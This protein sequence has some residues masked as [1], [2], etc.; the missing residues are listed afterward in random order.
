MINPTARDLARRPPTEPLQRRGSLKPLK[1]VSL[2]QAHP[3]VNILLIGPYGAGKTILAGSAAAD[4]RIKR[5]LYM[6]FDDGTMSLQPV[7]P[8]QISLEHAE[9]IRVKPIKNFMVDL[10]ETTRYLEE[11]A[12][13]GFLEDDEFPK[14]DCIILDSLDESQKL[15]MEGIRREDNDAARETARKMGKNPDEIFPGRADWSDYGVNSTVLKSCIRRIKA[16][17]CHLIVTCKDQDKDDETTHTRQLLLPRSLAFD[18][19]GLFD[20]V[21]WIAQ[22]TR[23]NREEKKRE[24][25]HVLHCKTE[26]GGARIAKDRSRRLPAEI[27]WPTMTKIFDYLHIATNTEATEEETHANTHP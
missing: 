19:P 23:S 25:V 14:F 24:I 16:L 15:L 27:E 13:P 1:T 11:T 6:D 12:K 7:E 18:I 9:K 8:D 2:L 3:Y 26:P 22:E 4:P 20:E 17:P 21:L 10:N 5:V